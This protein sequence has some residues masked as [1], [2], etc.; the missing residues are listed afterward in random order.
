[1]DASS[2][3]SVLVPPGHRN[4]SENSTAA[5]AVFRRPPTVR[6]YAAASVRVNGDFKLIAGFGEFLSRANPRG[7]PGGLTAP[8]PLYRSRSGSPEKRFGRRPMA[9]PLILIDPQPR[10]L[11]EIFEPKV[12]AR[13]GSLGELAVHEGSGR[14]PA[15]R[16]ESQLPE[17]T[18]LIGQSDMPKARL[19]RAGKLRAI[20]NVV[21]NFLQNVDYGTCF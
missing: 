11:D 18:L 12:W 5:L 20:I 16:F 2:L 3:G 9:R 13:L 10:G 15:E 1:M 17:M 6:R 14:M 4:D 8:R 7:I 19:D 21:T